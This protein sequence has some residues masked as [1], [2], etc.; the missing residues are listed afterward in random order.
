MKRVC[1]LAIILTILLQSIVFAASQNDISLK[2]EENGIFVTANVDRAS[3]SYAMTVIKEGGEAKNP[4][5]VFAVREGKSGS[6]KTVSFFFKMPDERNGE[7][8]DGRYVINIKGKG[9]EKISR[10]FDYV[11]E[12]GKK[13]ALEKI[14]S[15]VSADELK[16]YFDKDNNIRAALLV[17]GFVFDDYDL[18][19]ES[20]KTEAVRLMKE[21]MK[22]ETLAEDF[23]LS[24]LL[25]KINTSDKITEWILKSG[26]EFE[27]VSFADSSAK[28]FIE[29]IILSKRV[30]NKFEEYENAYIEAN[31]L[32]LCNNAKYNEIYDIL[33][34][35]AKALSIEN[36]SD[37]QKYFALTGNS[38]QT[39]SEG[40]VKFLSGKN[41]ENMQALID[42]VKSG[43]S[44]TSST[45]GKG[46]TS[47]NVG[48]N[49]L[50]F[51]KNP[52][53]P[54]DN[55]SVNKPTDGFIDLASVPWAENAINELSRRGVVSGI[56][57]RLFDPKG[58]VT[59]EAF[60]K[61]LI[62][63][64]EMDESGL[65]SNYSDIVKGAWYESYVASASKR[66]IVSGI[67]ENT[68]GVGMDITRQDVAVMIAKAIE[69]GDAVDEF[70]FSDDDNISE[71]A[72]KSVYKLYSAGIISGMEDKS[73]MPK[74]SCTRAEAAVIIYNMINYKPKSAKVNTKYE[75][76]INILTA[77]GFLKGITPE[78]FDENNYFVRQRFIASA[79]SMAKSGEMTDTQ[80]V[81]YA[82]SIGMIDRGDND[83]NSYITY[84]EA[85]KILVNLLGYKE[86]YKNR[87]YISIAMEIG[88]L[89]NTQRAEGKPAS[90]GD[91][92][93]M[94]YNALDIPVVTVSSASSDGLSAEI[95]KD[96]TILSVY[97]SVAEVRG[98]VTQNENTS[99]TGASTAGRN[100][101]EINGVIYDAGTSNAEDFLGMNVKAYVCL[102]KS[103]DIGKVMYIEGYRNTVTKI[104]AELLE[105]VKSSSISYYPEKNSAKSKT[106]KISPVVKVIYNGRA[107]SDY[108]TEDFDIDC[109]RLRLIDN[110]DDNTADVIFIEEYEVMVV[111]SVSR[112]NETIYNKYKT[113]DS[114][115]LEEDGKLT[116]LLN[117]EAVE[118]TSLSEN[119]VLAVMASK[120]VSDPI[121][122]IEASDKT[123]FGVLNRIDYN[124]EEV[125]ID[126]EVYKLSTGYMRAMRENDDKL[127]IMNIGEKYTFYLDPF[128]AAAYLVQGEESAYEYAYLKK[129]QYDDGAV[130]ETLALR[131]LNMNGAWESAKL[132][133]RVKYSG[134]DKSEDDERI[135]VTASRDK[136]FNIMGGSNFTQQ[137]ARIKKNAKGEISSIETAKESKEYTRDGFDKRSF[138]EELQWGTNNSSFDSKIFCG[139]DTK[140]IRIPSEKSGDESEYEVTGRSLF[141]VD[142]RYSVTA[143]GL[144]EYNYAKIVVIPQK[145]SIAAGAAAF[146]VASKGSQEVNGEVLPTLTGIVGENT[147]YTVVGETEDMF[148][149]VEKGDIIQLAVNV[150][151]RVYQYNMVY[152]V[153]DSYG[154]K[155]NPS[156]INSSVADVAGFV[157]NVD[158]SGNRLKIDNGQDGGLTIIKD[159]S[160]RIA[161]YDMKRKTVEE[162]S[163]GEIEKGDYIYARL[164]WSRLKIMLVIREK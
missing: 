154:T 35:Y 43:M 22:N 58:N 53:V 133:E 82:K 7:K 54:T 33:Q 112:V 148:D 136:I 161:L 31:A 49:T 158:R 55:P 68:F 93:Q 78:S 95:N 60:V 122:S 106:V 98:K 123:V 18:F 135:S 65:Q 5:D 79:A 48:G 21:N 160:A 67:D 74:G 97:H 42:A 143:Y 50:T 155:I 126:G 120:D 19:S 129:F 149:E 85:S 91:I 89:K 64:L 153:K 130:E 100:G 124:E 146:V 88:L 3:W 8:T 51:G 113:P 37:C 77:F 73:F 125:T 162:I 116:V 96:N 20:E 138:A 23:M 92:V 16:N 34:K 157:T 15:A 62:T 1:S 10:V 147:E 70:V 84:E 75:K 2:F 38:R 59:R 110:D 139:E 94:L 108:K 83:L 36:N 150:S 30:F 151:G 121:I 28:A 63:A 141:V 26:M 12:Q 142:G 87:N 71:Y 72:K 46:N 6:D 163:I 69:L 107:Y 127:P 152:S 101:V 9:S 17:N 109:G 128:G 40:I 39:A 81:E 76:Q 105:E 140:V 24:A 119:N 14:T 45:G 27:G 44:E 145:S 4:Q 131:F 156:K 56:G 25:A 90:A 115:K 118:Y 132:A 137:L 13:E 47:S 103:L 159:N 57:D 134:E 99:L 32:Y 29:K 102:D 111:D 114:L 164:G 86:V 144:D 61:M 117:G 52:N 41:A 11:T 66:N 80:A 104:D